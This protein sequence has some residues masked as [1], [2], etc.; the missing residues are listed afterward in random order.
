MLNKRKCTLFNIF[1]N[2]LNLNDDSKK[3]IKDNIKANQI[4]EEW[5]MQ[6]I[7]ARKLLINNELLQITNNF[8]ERINRIIK[9]IYLEKQT[10]LTFVE[11][12]YEITLICENLV[13]NHTEKL[14]YEARFV[15]TFNA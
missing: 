10:V 12:L 11:G 7:D 5:Y 2:N 6:F 4:C 9:A 14:I 15:T 1:I 13:K 3:K 8:T